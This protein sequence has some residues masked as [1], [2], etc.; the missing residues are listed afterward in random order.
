[1]GAKCFFC[2]Y[3][4]E[5]GR[6]KNCL[7]EFSFKVTRPDG[8]SMVTRPDGECSKNLVSNPGS[9]SDIV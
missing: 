3:V 1:M 4:E 8:E 9:S 2:V 7:G 5:T 6:V